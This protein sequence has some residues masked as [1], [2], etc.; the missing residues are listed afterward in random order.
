MQAIKR[1]KLHPDHSHEHGKLACKRVCQNETT[2]SHVKRHPGITIQE[3]FYRL[4]TCFFLLETYNSLPCAPA[5][6]QVAAVP[7]ASEQVR[8][9]DVDATNK[10][11]EITATLVT[12]IE[13]IAAWMMGQYAKIA[14]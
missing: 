8:K 5:R 13:T 4:E 2:W 1:R 9:I 14:S 12:A 10:L 7:F 6:M 11:Y 3:V